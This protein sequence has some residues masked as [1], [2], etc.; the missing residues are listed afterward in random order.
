M[1]Q[2]TLKKWK[3]SYLLASKVLLGRIEKLGG[4]MTNLTMKIKHI[5]RLL[6]ISVTFNFCEI[7]L[8][9]YIF[10]EHGK[11]LINAQEQKS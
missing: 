6:L 5:V 10:M 11:L 7:N 9:T 4:E 1:Q 8:I 3:V 2:L